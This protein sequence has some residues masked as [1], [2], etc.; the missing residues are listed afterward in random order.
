MS[1]TPVLF[2]FFGLSAKINTHT[3]NSKPHSKP[4]NQQTVVNMTAISCFWVA[5]LSQKSGKF[6]S[7]LKN[8][9][10]QK[11]HFD[12]IFDFLDE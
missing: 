9:I 11:H 4:A 12:S 3:T 6:H 7:L 8:K 10:N 5:D 1:F 2:S